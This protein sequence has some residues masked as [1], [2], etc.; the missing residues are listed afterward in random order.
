MSSFTNSIAGRVLYIDNEVKSYSFPSL[1]SIIPHPKSEVLIIITSTDSNQNPV[2]SGVQVDYTKITIP[3]VFADRNECIEYLNRYIFISHVNIQSTGRN[4][5]TLFGDDIRTTRRVP[6]E[7]GMWVHGLPVYG[8]DYEIVGSGRWYVL[9]DLVTPSLF[10][11]VSVLE[12]GTDANGKIYI[13]SKRL[14]RY[15]PGQLSY[16]IFTAAWLNLLSANGDFLLLFGATL[17]GLASDGQFGLIK[18]GVVVGFKKVGGELK[19]IMRVYKNFQHTEEEYDF[20]DDELLNLKILRLEIGYLGIHPASV[21]KVNF[22][23]LTDEL[24]HTVVFDQDTVSVG[25]PNLAASI[26]LENIGNT[27]NL[28][29]RNGSFQV[30]NY[31]ER[32]SPDPSS[33]PLFDSFEAAAISSG[34]DTVIAAYTV[35]EKLTMNKELNSAGVLNGIFRNTVANKLN[36]AQAKGIANKSIVLNIYLV[37]KTDVVATYTPLSPFINAIERATGAAIISVSLT[38]AIKIG[39]LNDINT[40]KFLDISNQDILLTSDLVG[41]I[42]VS[43]AQS[44]TDLSYIIST[45]DLF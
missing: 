36:T 6:V 10:D 45:E 40:G 5:G 19:H 27:T 22:K 29:V 9:P 41:I 28:E 33:R 30:G 23:A 3:K 8:I 20:D 31:S 14:N 12:T 24:V 21:S 4:T 13:S 34:T 39:A 17:R 25:N 35:P 2:I 7:S 15:Q 26:Y 44:I 37:P 16:F 18:D 32:S 1:S 11:G 38:N 42:T 43:C